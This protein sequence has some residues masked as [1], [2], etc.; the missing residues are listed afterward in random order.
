MDLVRGLLTC[1]IIFWKWLE[2]SGCECSSIFP[3]II[4]V[5]A[6]AHHDK[7]HVMKSVFIHAC[8]NVLNNRDYTIA[9]FLLYPAPSLVPK[10][11]PSCS[12]YPSYRPVSCFIHLCLYRLL[13]VTFSQGVFSNVDAYADLLSY[14]EPIGWVLFWSPLSFERLPSLDI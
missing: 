2:T 4:A 13:D 10:R 11:D 3:G 5:N 12:T 14:I 6:N 7:F 1:T 9:Y 8:L